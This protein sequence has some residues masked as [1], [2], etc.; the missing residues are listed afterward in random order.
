MG[1][2]PE[3]SPRITPRRAL[4]SLQRPPVVAAIVFVET[5]LKVGEHK[6]GQTLH[7]STKGVTLLHKSTKA[8]HKRGQVFAVTAIELAG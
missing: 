3:V 1:S 7:K 4:H 8:K 6:W 5:A 2:A